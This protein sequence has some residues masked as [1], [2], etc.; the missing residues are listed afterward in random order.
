MNEESVII[1][2][3]RK[4]AMPWI[5]A[6]DGQEIESR[7]LV[8]NEAIINVVLGLSPK[9]VLDIGCGEGWLVRELEKSGI[10]ALGI[11]AIP[12]FIAAAKN[13]GKGRF[14][15]LTYEDLS[16]SNIREKFDVVVCN[17]SL[18]GKE[19]VSRV[20]SSAPQ[21]LN[22]GR[23]FVV[24]T[25][26]PDVLAK[27]MQHTG[28]SWVKGSWAGFHET[29]QDPAPWYFRTIGTWKRLFSESGFELVN[30]IEPIHPRTGVPAS[31]IFVGNIGN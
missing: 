21:L 25:L 18:F 19:S 1:E 29:F 4:N 7:I 23:S 27:E 28:D 26:H 16:F 9:K 20:F 30:V 6:I 10:D 12:K 2:S 13:K 3:W 15:T 5:Q 31:I 11:D 8:T 22:I 24:Q 14:R 17:F